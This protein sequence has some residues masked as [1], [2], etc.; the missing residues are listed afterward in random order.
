MP[1]V[2][3]PSVCI[4]TRGRPVHAPAAAII[5]R[6]VFVARQSV[7]STGRAAGTLYPKCNGRRSPRPGAGCGGDGKPT[8]GCVPPT[9][10][11]P[12]GMICQISCLDVGLRFGLNRSQTS[13]PRGNRRHHPGCG[14]SE[15][16]PGRVGRKRSGWRSLP[17]ARACMRL[18]AQGKKSWIGRDVRAPPFLLRRA[19]PPLGCVHLCMCYLRVHVCIC[20]VYMCT[21]ACVY[22]YEHVLCIR[23]STCLYACMSVCSPCVYVCICTLYSAPH[24]PGPPAS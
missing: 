24:P 22:M 6:A 14:G 19:R 12:T 11:A 2:P 20:S 13:G 7:G 1:N 15:M 9:C 17:P 5:S 4:Y 23:V 21:G 3:S 8:G 16:L 18:K 10:S